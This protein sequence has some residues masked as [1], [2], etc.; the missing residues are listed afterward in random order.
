MLTWLSIRSAFGAILDWKILIGNIIHFIFFNIAHKQIQPL[1]FDTK[2]NYV[3]LKRY[4]Y[5]S[6]CVEIE[7]KPVSGINL[8]YIYIFEKHTVVQIFSFQVKYVRYE[9]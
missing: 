3:N 2:K 7:T 9:A 6:R 8:V 4:I 5:K 1:K